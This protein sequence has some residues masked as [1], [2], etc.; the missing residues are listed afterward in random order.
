[1]EKTKKAFR[2]L[3]NQRDQADLLAG[4]GRWK[5]K[6]RGPVSRFYGDYLYAQ[7]REMFNLEYSEWVKK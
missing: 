3:L 2:E 5:N 4:N 7:D 1:M 6:K